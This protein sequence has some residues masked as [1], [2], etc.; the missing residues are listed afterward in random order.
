MSKWNVL[1]FIL[2]AGLIAIIV[3][4]ILTVK[5]GAT[6]EPLKAIP[7][8]ASVIIKVND[9]QNF[10]QESLVRSSTW[11]ELKAIP[12]FDRL[13]RQIQFLDSL[14]RNMPEARDLLQAK[15]SY[16]SA[17]FTGKDRI[18]FMHVFKLPG[19][20]NE[21]RINDLIH[22]LIIDQGTVNS[23][24]YEGVNIYEVN[25]LSQEY[26]GNFS[27]A[28]TNGNFLLSFSSIVLE[29]AIRQLVSDG[30][31]IRQEGFQEMFTA[32]LKNASVDANI[33]MNFRELPRSISTL[34]KPEFKAEV[35]SFDTFSDWGELDVNTMPD[36]LL[37]NGFVHNSDSVVSAASL[38][39][40]QNPQR[41]TSDEVL[42]ATVSVFLTLSFS[43]VNRYFEDY[44][45]Y[46]RELG[47]YTNYCNTLRSLDNT[48]DLDFLGAFKE[49]LDQEVTL[50][51][52]AGNAENDA[53]GT[54][55][56]MR[57]KSRALAEEKMNGIL[58][59]IASSESKTPDSYTHR[60]RFDSELSF[61]IHHLP[62]KKLSGK[63][64]GS[65]FAGLDEHFYVFLDNYLIFASS[66]EALEDLITSY[67]LNRTL[68]SVPSYKDFKN[69]ISSR[70]NICFYCKLNEGYRTFARYLNP[71]LVKKWEAHKQVFDKVQVLGFQLYSHNGMLYNNLL[72]KHLAS[73]G[74][75]SPTLWESKL[76]TVT[77]FKPT[78][79]LNHNTHQKEI[80]VQDISNNIYLIN[81]VGRILWKVPLNEKI[82]S[83]VYQ[84]DFYSN[85]KLQ[86]LFST[87]NHLYLL[88]RNGNYVEKYP[89]ELR[90][91]ATCGMSLI[92]YDNNGNYRIFIP[93]EDR[94]VYVYDKEGSL[95]S[96]WEFGTTE[97]IV[98]QPVQHFKVLDKDYIVFG[99]RF[100]TY[101]L[102]RRGNIRTNVTTYF[103]KSTGNRY[104]LDVPGRT[105]DAR[106]ITTDTAGMVYF[107]YLDGR[108]NTLELATCSNGHYFEC[109]D[110][111]GDGT[112]EYIFLENNIL[113]VYRNDRSKMFEIEFREAINDRPVCYEFSST[114][115]KIGIVARNDNL[116]YLISNN[117][118]IHRNFPLQGNTLFSI[119]YLDNAGTSFN[120]LVGSRNHFLYNYQLN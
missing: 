84:I 61:A 74:T 88:D 98:T 96:G 33:F 49:I 10:V 35:R 70:S 15:P 75:A 71:E 118:S 60:Y 50:A 114:D 21:K 62:I 101:I 18:S 93:C 83:E 67:I 92:D 44:H 108:V 77:D 26:I 34:V 4:L 120:L 14:Y 80:F 31:V 119:G 39:V 27:Y 105:A 24:K 73:S 109:H 19:K 56:L 28:V 113:T 7:V 25:L 85:G 78:F 42:P 100:R 58:N 110:L 5:P 52:D 90:S 99:D 107:I 65:L 106:L 66:R 46:L 103:Q 29:D 3:A 1:P 95:L 22:G 68:V 37:L 81:Q 111:N 2:I 8:D 17:H 43:D 16:I 86:L 97:N 54:L 51:F 117:G 38:F 115:R 59:S 82:N 87:A 6:S 112:R 116:I 40:N 48:Y 23:R 53:I 41:I 94:Q 20:L 47:R 64:F 76:D 63:L 79:V 91:P 30:S 32:A 102:D 57:V 104:F 12:E 72:V 9:F 69:S 11:E 55:F 13:N 36:A 89:V 45:E